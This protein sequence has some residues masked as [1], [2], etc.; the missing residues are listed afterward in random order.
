LFAEGEF[1]EVHVNAPLEI[2]EQRDPKGL[3]KRARKGEVKDFTGV[4]SVYEP[5]LDP[6]LILDTSQFT[7]EVLVEHLFKVFK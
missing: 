5:P 2:C 7:P 3:Y 6:E 1:I 4:D